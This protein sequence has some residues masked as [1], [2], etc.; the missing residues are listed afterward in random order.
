MKFEEMPLKEKLN[1]PY[2]YKVQLSISIIQKMYDKWDGRV[3]VY[4]RT[5]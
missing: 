1:L 2:R 4:D 3:H 5:R